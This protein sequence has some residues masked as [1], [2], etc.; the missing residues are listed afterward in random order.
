M[1]DFVTGSVSNVPDSFSGSGTT[2]INSIIRQMSNENT[3]RTFAYNSE[4]A[5]KARDFSEYMSN[6]SH[7]R[8]VDDLKRAGLNPVLSSNGGAS[9]YS[10]SSASG[11]ADN[12]AVGLIASIYQTKMNND[13][14]IKIAKMQN[15]NNLEIAKINAAA[16]NYASNN[17]SSASKYASDMSASASRYA[18]DTGYKGRKLAYGSTDAGMIDSLGLGS[19]GN[20]IAKGAYLGVKSFSGL[21]SAFINRGKKKK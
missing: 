18:T 6:S 2:D 7:Q 9:A 14:A 11:T 1:S 13:N 17:S 4:E 19:T 8:E 12:S 16:S 5:Q 15:N 3:A 10:A 21:A 20:K